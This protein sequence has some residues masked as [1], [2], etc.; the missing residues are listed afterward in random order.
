M[1]TLFLS[2]SP[3]ARPSTVCDTLTSL[4]I[5]CCS[6]PVLLLS[7]HVV[8]PHRTCAL[9]LFFLQDRSLLLRFSALRRVS[10]N[11][12]SICVCFTPQSPASS[13]F[14]SFSLSPFDVHVFPTQTIEYPCVP[15]SGRAHVKSTLHAQRVCWAP[16]VLI[17]ATLLQHCFSVISSS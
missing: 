7:M 2:L 16:A 4:C 10:V 1:L 3:E 9:L 14:Q 13:T 8:C 12:D 5:Q 11:P 17:R 15:F 6:S